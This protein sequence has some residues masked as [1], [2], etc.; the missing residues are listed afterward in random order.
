MFSTLIAILLAAVTADNPPPASRPAPA[1]ATR[2]SE[3]RLNLKRDGA[4]GFPQSQA[5]I[6][7]DDENLRV[8]AW[9]DADYLYVQSILWKDGDDSLGE[10]R[11]GREIGDNSS[12]CLDLDA[13]QK[14]TP[15]LDRDYALNPWPKRPGLY[16]SVWLS[17]NSSTHLMNDSKG[18]GSIRYLN[19]ATDRR[20]RV[21]SFL[22]PLSEIKKK[23][24]Q[25][26]RLAY[27]AYSPKPAFTLNSVGAQGRGANTNPPA[28]DKYHPLKLQDRP[29]T[30]DPQQVP[31]GREDQVPAT[32]RP[33]KP[34]PKLDTVPPE[35]KAK[36]WLNTDQTP[37]LASLKG[38]VIVLD[39][40]GTWCGPCVAGIP[41]LNELHE[42]HAARG[43]R[44]LGIT[45]QSRQGIENFMKTTPVKYILG[46]GSNMAPEYGITGFPHAFIIGRDGKLVWQGNPGSADFEKRLLVALDAK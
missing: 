46:T 42:Q 18:R 40:W 31:E 43:L 38:K 41:H 36:D 6:L 5:E 45:D 1:A 39:F 44:I 15:K 9:S 20:V 37:T 32:T 21:D 24:G 7:C 17:A 2:P 22:I 35:L 27:T 26:L 29:A 33:T 11:D 30:L 13:D 8:S 4:F 23:P 3:T 19:V 34:V 25:G 10:T 14:L 12:L 16:Y 28:R